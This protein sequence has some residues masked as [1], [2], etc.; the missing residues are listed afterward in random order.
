MARAHIGSKIREHRKELG[1]TQ[2]A[3]AEEVGISASYLNLIEANKR[4]IGGRLLQKVAA[5][6]KVDLDKLDGALEKRLAEH[7]DELTTEPIL[8]SLEINPASTFDLIGRHPKWARA[9]IMIYRAFQDQ[10]AHASALSDRL[11]HDPFLSN[12]VHNMLTNVAAIRSAAEILEG[13]DDLGVDDRARFDRII[14]SESQRLADVSARLAAY[15]DS[16]GTQIRSLTPAEEVDDF[17]WERGN[18]FPKLEAATATLLV[19]R[20]GGCEPNDLSLVAA[21]K[22]DGI[23]IRDQTETSLTDLV[24]RN[25]CYLDHA[26]GCLIFVDTAALSTRRFQMAR[27]LADRLLGDVIA[28]EI[29]GQE[30]LTSVTSQ[31]RASRA[32]S[33]YAAGAMLMPYSGFLR[34]AIDFRYDIDRL[35]H[36]YKVSFEQACHRLVTLKRPDAAGI[37][38]AFIRADAAGVVTKRYPLQQLPLPRH[39]HVCPLWTVYSA[40]Q[41]PSRIVREMAELPSGDRFLFVAR[42]AAKDQAVFQAYQPAVSVMIACD[43]IHADQTVYGDGLDATAASIATPIGPTCRLCTRETCRHREEDPIVGA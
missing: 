10:T 1:L 41:R 29:D 12:A 32:L 37:P 30:R 3:L 42:A 20:F 36:R 35:A 5:V 19:E 7:L 16:A 2:A 31:E 24:L 26:A 15:F 43:G 25:S 38:F 39:G 33:S 9:L 22:D 17:L 4:Q 11:N 23:E 6:L 8:K 27:L 14:G 28:A 21:L 40:F 13:T 34:D 18:Y